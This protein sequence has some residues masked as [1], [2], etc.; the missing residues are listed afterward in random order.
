MAEVAAAVQATADAAATEA[1]VD[2]PMGWTA[3]TIILDKRDLATKM[4]LTLLY[5]KEEMHPFVYEV[6]GRNRLGRVAQR[7]PFVAVL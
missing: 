6:R 2:V 1:P 7:M 4:G 5:L 3:E